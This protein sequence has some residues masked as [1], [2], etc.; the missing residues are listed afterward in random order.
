MRGQLTV[1]GLLV[2]IAYLGAVYG[3]LSSIAHTTGQLQGALAGARRVRAMLALVPETRRPARRDRR[4]GDHRRGPV[5]ATSASPTRTAP[6]CCTTSASTAAAG[7]DGRARRPDRRR[8]D[9]A[10]QPDSALLRADGGPRADRRRRRARSTSCGRCASASRSCCRI[11]C[12]SPA[13]SPTTCATAGSTRRREEIE[14]AARAAHAHDFI[15]A[16]AEGLRHQVAEAGGSL[17]GGE[18]Q[19]L[20]IAR[21]HAEE[22]AD[23]DPRR[24]DLVAR[25]D[26]RGDRLRRAPAAARRAARRSSSRTGCRPSATPIASSCSTR[27]ASPRRAATTSC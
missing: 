19:R 4:V 21:A 24:A 6:T 23:P 27:A 25:R 20:S 11:R 10:G 2:V 3:P 16:P 14:E 8:Q 18:R 13:R 22:R 12:C 1:G 7:R 5:R 15:I 17:S 9:D 26:L